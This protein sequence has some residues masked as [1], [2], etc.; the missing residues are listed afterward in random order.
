MQRFSIRLRLAFPAKRIKIKLEERGNKGRFEHA[1][2][3][4][5]SRACPVD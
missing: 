5:D 3:D 4:F 2:L 1:E